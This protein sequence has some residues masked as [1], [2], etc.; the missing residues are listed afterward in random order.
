MTVYTTCSSSLTAT[1]LAVQALRGGECGVALS[2]GVNVI[3]NAHNH[4]I[5]TLGGVLAAT[6]SAR[7]STNGPT[8]TP[9]PR[10]A[11]SSSSSGCP[12]RDGTA[13]PSTP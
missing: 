12:T 4:T 9:A 7:P 3:H 5:L 10:A 8:A 6:A 2:G 13:T 1:H 11:A